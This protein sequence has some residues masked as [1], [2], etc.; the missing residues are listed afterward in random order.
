MVS[1]C[2]LYYPTIDISDEAW[3]KNA[4]LFW[5]GIRTIVPSSLDRKA[6]HNY[7]T[8][9]LEGE[10]YLRPILITPDSS[11]VKNLVSKV[12]S[13]AT[14][15]EGIA[16][17]NQEVPYD[18]SNN[19][20]SDE[21]AA[22]YLHSEKLP[23][24]LQEMLRERV[25]NDGWVRVSNNF[26]NYYM[27]LL[28]N[29][30]ANER[31]LTLLTGS[32][33]LANLTT[34]RSENSVSHHFTTEGISQAAI[35]QTFLVRMIIDGIRIN[36]LTSLDDLKSFKEHHRDELNNFRNSLD[37]ITSMNIPEGMDYEGMVQAVKDIYERKVI[38]ACNNLKSALKGDRINFLTDMSSVLY[39]GTTTAFLNTMV[40]LSEPMRLLVGAGIFVTVKV[41]KE[42]ASKKK[43]RRTSKMSYLLSI[44][45]ELR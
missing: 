7:S 21:R 18:V 6:Y 28:A 43:I 42:H 23:I 4:Y 24:V 27:T 9:F 41:V 31:S 8:Q 32:P 3:L 38:L 15:K 35:C 40:D 16:C 5:D 20:Y 37:E 45:R 39:T 1:S 36:P 22:F 19:P 26:A 44:N 17:L 2:A 25:G 10:G 11:V 30:I 12:K 13:Y 14:S 34:I 29:D 33:T